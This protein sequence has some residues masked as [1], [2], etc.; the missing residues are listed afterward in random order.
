MKLSIMIFTCYLFVQY[1]VYLLDQHHNT[2]MYHM[3][4]YTVYII[5]IIKHD[6]YCKI[7]VKL[8]K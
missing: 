1:T 4:T 2:C 3:Y 5:N 8:E 6:C 7:I